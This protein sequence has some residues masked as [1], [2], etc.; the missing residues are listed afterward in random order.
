M[1]RGIIS[2]VVMISLVLVLVGCTSRPG[3]DASQEPEEVYR[4]TRGLVMKFA[5]NQP[6]SKIY[7]TTSLNVL[8]ELE[9]KGTSDLSGSRCWLYLSGY[10]PNIIR[11]INQRKLCS[12][13]LEGKSVFNPEGGFSTQQF[14]TDLIDLPEFMDSLPQKILATACYEYITSASPV[15]CIDPRQYEIG[16]IERA[17]NVRDIS[18]GGGQGAPVAVTFVGV[19]MAGRDKIAFTIRISN[20]GGGTPFYRGTS[21]SRDCPNNIAVQDYNIVNYFVDMTG[22]SK[23]RC[24]P[25]IEGEEKVRLVNGKANIF[26]TFNVRGNSAY[27]TPLLIDLDYNYQDS[28]S[29]NIELIKTPE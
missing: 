15:V 19:E 18:L 9:N 2:I 29:K 21:L 3:P 25:E 5:Q 17:C 7:D 24:S 14:S 26:C 6:Q 13:A 10:D 11:G 20:V 12:T 22:G 16:P 8:L 27:T 28:I 23:I 1:K 4:G